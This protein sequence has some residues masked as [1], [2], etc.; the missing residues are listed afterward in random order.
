MGLGTGSDGRT[1]GRMGGWEALSQGSPGRTR[2]L[3]PVVEE[4]ERGALLELPLDAG[5]APAGPV[6]RAGDVGGCQG[7]AMLTPSPPPLRKS[8][9][10]LRHR[11][12]WGSGGLGTSPA[13]STGGAGGCGLAALPRDNGVGGG[14]GGLGCRGGTLTHVFRHFFG[15]GGDLGSH[16]GRCGGGGERTRL[17]NLEGPQRWDAR[18]QPGQGGHRAP[19][20]SGD[21]PQG[22][23]D[24]MLC[25]AVAAPGAGKSRPACSGRCL[26]CHVVVTSRPARFLPGFAGNRPGRFATPC[27]L[28]THRRPRLPH[29]CAHASSQPAHA[30]PALPRGRR[31]CHATVGHGSA[32]WGCRAGESVPAAG[33]VPAEPQRPP[34]QPPRPPVLGLGKVAVP[35][36]ESRRG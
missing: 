32:S 12:V 3:S 29:V 27:P 10:G 8:T 9:L 16:Q 25:R 20:G 22:R 36:R 28:R 1:D 13:R 35:A 34:A 14:V 17:R 26:R 2:Q 33:R 31:R 21:G 18:L 11:G 7:R 4:D 19:R 15:L 6:R 30:C 23:G 5:V 24:G